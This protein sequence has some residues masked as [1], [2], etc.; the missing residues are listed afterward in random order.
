MVPFDLP[1]SAEVNKVIPKNAFHPRL[2]AD[3]KTTL[4]SKVERITWTHVLKPETTNLP[5]NEIQEVQVIH[6]KLRERADLKSLRL[7]MEKVIPYTLVFWFEFSG[8]AFLSSSKKHTHAIAEDSS[9]LDWNFTSD[10]FPVDA[11]PY[12]LKL[13][14]SLDEVA[15]RLWFDLSGNQYD[16]AV[17]SVS[18]LTEDLAE[19]YRMQREIVHLEQKIRRER[20][21][22]KKVQMNLRLVELR[23]QLSLE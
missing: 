1:K 22:N 9:V 19:R 16:A 23:R 6:V 3:Q 10:W 2:T 20:Q 4:T 15:K 14:G 5:A 8:E 18:E 11:C 13:S 7:A 21:F 17:S 12:T